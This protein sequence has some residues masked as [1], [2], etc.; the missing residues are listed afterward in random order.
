MT[1]KNNCTAYSTTT[2]FIL[3]TSTLDEYYITLHTLLHNNALA[4]GSQNYGPRTKSGP[5]SHFTRP[6]KP[7]CQ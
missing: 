1:S 2:G 6:T 3:D 5:R 4:Q 7:F